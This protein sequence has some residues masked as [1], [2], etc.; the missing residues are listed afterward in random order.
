MNKVYRLIWSRTREMWVAV[1]EKVAAGWFR[2]P[3][4][5]GALVISAMLAAGG[6]AQAVDPNTLP[7]G[8]QVV[9]GQASIAQAGNAMTVTQRTDKMIANWN[10]FNIG[11]NASVAFQQP[12][13]ASVALN[14]IFDQNPSQIFGSLSANGQVFLLNPA[15]VYFGS[16]ARVD[17][18]GLVASSLNLSNENFLAGKYRFENSGIAGAIINK[19]EIRTAAGG[20]VAFLSPQ[21][22]NEGMITAPNGMVALAAGD[23]V[24]LD[25][26]GDKLVSFTVDQGA[27]DALIESKGIIKVDGG[28]VMLTA[29]AANELTTSV[30]NNTGIIEATGIS[31]QAG[32]I[33]LDAEGGITTVSGMLDASS[34]DGMGGRIVATGD[35]VLVKD[36]AHLNA[37]GATGGG[38]VLVGGGWQGSDS[39]IPIEAMAAR[40]WR[41]Q[42]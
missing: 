4:T 35:R 37:S 21:I 40:L 31:A 7:T 6:Q 38:E 19:G 16:T 18:G 34:S 10:T 36:G 28:L 5:V 14:R 22:T 41:G 30:V 27:I 32:R 23:K 17:V 2:R 39:T 33:I 3:L 29:K 13:A 15:G 20:Y 26:T 9:A 8:G 42:M 25:F 11:Q 12:G 1:C 24:S